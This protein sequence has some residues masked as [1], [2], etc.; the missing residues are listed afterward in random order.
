VSVTAAEHA[1]LIRMMT[2]GKT[3]SGGLTASSVAARNALLA[4]Y[5]AWVRKT[6][7]AATP[8]TTDDSGC[9]EEAVAESLLRCVERLSDYDPR[10][11]VALSD[12]MVSSRSVSATIP[13]SAQL[14]G[15]A[16]LD[17]NDLPQLSPV[18]EPL[19]ISWGLLFKG[20]TPA[21]SEVT[22]LHIGVGTHVLTI[23]E[24][25]A[26]LEVTEDAVAHLW[27][28]AVRALRR[29]LIVGGGSVVQPLM[30]GSRSR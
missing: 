14:L 19:P 25:A 1:R 2:C 15:H 20:L 17:D 22:R 11:G 4:A 9:V 24:I 30:Q 13:Q 7:T 16:F 21:Q 8:A 5:T 27:H 29:E 18:Y 23:A 12:W 10:G 3:V 28:R 6:V 26:V